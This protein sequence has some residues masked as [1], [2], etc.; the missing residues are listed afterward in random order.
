MPQSHN[1]TLPG[2]QTKDGSGTNN[3]SPN[4]TYETTDAHGKKKLGKAIT[5][6]T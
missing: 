5:K 1:T 2:H 4:D 6:V 3:D